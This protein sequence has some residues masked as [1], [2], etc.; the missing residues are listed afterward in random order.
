MDPIDFEFS[1]EVTK[2]FCGNTVN[3]L[4]YL[5][6]KGEKWKIDWSYVY[7]YGVTDK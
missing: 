3:I 1:Y 5:D 4:L 6:E 2:I 7:K